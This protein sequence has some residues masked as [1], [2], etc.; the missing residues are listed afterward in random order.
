[1]PDHERF[2]IAGPPAVVEPLVDAISRDPEVTVI[3][4]PHGGPA[5]PE[6]FVVSMTADLAL[7][8]RSALGPVLTI[9]P[10]E[11][12]SPADGTVTPM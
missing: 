11:P 7:G 3:E 8:L 12:L 2:I 1:M 6:R 4:G 10:D 5:G 9:E